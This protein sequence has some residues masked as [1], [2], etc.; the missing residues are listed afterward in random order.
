MER[1]NVLMSNSLKGMFFDCVIIEY[2]LI[3]RQE[4]VP[5]EKLI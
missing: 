2:L 3:S 4:L 1:T 5:K